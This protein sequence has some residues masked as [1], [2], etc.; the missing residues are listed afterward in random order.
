MS[1]L[2]DSVD[3]KKRDTATE[4]L[5]T[6]QKAQNN[7]GVQFSD[8]HRYFVEPS[9]FTTLKRGGPMNNF[10]VEVIAYLGGY[11]FSNGKEYLPYKLLTFNQR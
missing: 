1:S 2:T 4:V 6:D 11:L 8:Q 10:Q 5:P 9:V 3:N 7:A